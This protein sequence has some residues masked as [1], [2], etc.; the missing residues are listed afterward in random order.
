MQ[1]L[2]EPKFKKKQLKAETNENIFFVT[3]M[4]RDINL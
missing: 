3:T 2:L 4:L 1:A